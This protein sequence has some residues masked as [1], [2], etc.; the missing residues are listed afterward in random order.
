V[1]TFTVQDPTSDRIAMVLVFPSFEAAQTARQQAAARDGESDPANQHPH[2]VPG[3]G[4]SEWR[5]NIALVQSSLFDLG[6]LYAAQYEDG[7]VTMVR[8]N[9]VA[10]DGLA[11]R[12]LEVGRDVDADLV[13]II[14]DGVRVDL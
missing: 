7:I 2:L 10:D 1:T 5:G 13:A 3:Y 4:R 14:T 12:P 6:R 9:G 8:T 11:M